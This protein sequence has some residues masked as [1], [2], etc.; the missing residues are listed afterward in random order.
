MEKFDEARIGNSR[1]ENERL[2]DEYLQD[3]RCGNKE[4]GTDFCIEGCPFLTEAESW[5]IRGYGCISFSA[6]LTIR[7][8]K[9]VK[10]IE[11]QNQK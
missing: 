9:P 2:L 11:C 4:P 5:F 7:Q 10:C 3:V 1:E 8:G 6:W